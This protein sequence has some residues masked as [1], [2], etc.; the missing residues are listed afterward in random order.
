MG[1]KQPEC[2]FLWDKGKNQ[3]LSD[4]YNF[5][6]IYWSFAFL[7]RKKDIRSH[8]PHRIPSFPMFP[9]GRKYLWRKARPEYRGELSKPRRPSGNTQRG[10]PMPMPMLVW[11]LLQGYVKSLFEVYP[12]SIFAEN[13]DP[14]SPGCWRKN[15]GS[16]VFAP[17][18]EKPVKP[19]HNSDCLDG[20]TVWTD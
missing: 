9:A 7:K 6:K 20:I 11:V 12:Y 14:C 5:L 19:S 1:L 18:T 8:D 10:M 2:Q 4:V 3:K 17:I 13:R 16:K 15:R